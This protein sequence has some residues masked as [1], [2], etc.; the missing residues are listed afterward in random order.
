MANACNDAYN[1]AL[2]TFCNFLLP[3]SPVLLFAFDG[4]HLVFLE[5][6]FAHKASL[7]VK[8]FLCLAFFFF[9]QN[10]ELTKFSANNS[11]FLAI[12]KETK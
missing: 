4:T 5:K 3:W 6:L 2:F 1:S 9:K 8:N 12:I 10:F 11:K 7:Q